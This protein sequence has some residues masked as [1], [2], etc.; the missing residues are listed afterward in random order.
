MRIVAATAAFIVTWCCA[1]PAFAVRITPADHRILASIAS[2]ALSPDGRSVA[3]IVRRTDYGTDTSPADLTIIDVAT[4]RERRPYF[5]RPGLA[6]PAW[7]PDG[8][9]LAFLAKRDDK[10]PAQINV[11]S[12]GGGDALTLT[13]TESG[14]QQFA[15]R[16][17]GAAIAYVTADADAHKAAI[18]AHHDYFEIV[19]DDYRTTA[20]IPPSHIWLVPSAGGTAERLTHGAWSV[21]T[22]YPP[23]PPSSPLSWSRD[24]TALL[25][26][27]VPNTHDGDAYLS[28]V[29]RL[30][31]ATGII[32]PLTSHG[33]LEGYA[34]F[35]P[36]GSRIAY[37]YPRDGDP[38]S[39]NEIFVTA[40]AGDAGTDVSRA[41]DRNVYRAIWLPDGSILTGAHEGTHSSLFRIARDGS[42]TKIDTGDV[43]PLV[44]YWFDASVSRTGALAFVGSQPHHPSELFYA[45]SVGAKPRRLTDINAEIAT[46][47]Q[48]RS[49]PIAW[50]GT[51]G[52]PE[53]GVVTYPPDFRPGR[54]YPLVVFVH[55]GPTAAS[56]AGFSLIP[57]EFAARGYLV[58]EPNY[59]GS[60]N[61]GNVY[62]RSIYNDAGAGPG[63][64]VMAGLAVLESQGHVDPSRIAVAGWSY[65][66]FMTTWLMGH[67]HVWKTAIAGA[68]VTN[69]VDMYNLGDGGA[70]IAFG[71]KGSPYVGDT[72]RD[73]IAQSPITEAGKTTCPVLI[74]HDVDDV[75]VP[76][77]QSY[78]L[79]HELSDNHVP[80]TF[81]GIPIAGHN[82]SDPVRIIE[83]ETRFL[84]WLDTHLK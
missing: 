22:S 60:D 49:E 30:E 53:D 77:T 80:V 1:A 83:R 39:E 17:D 8:S 41:L 35:S 5:E 21:T 62:Q 15:W 20:E 33:R 38:E 68:A 24:G 18:A 7:S 27:Q 78:E 26:T 57:Q 48:G 37:L 12:L 65:G 25:F 71:F 63:R 75:R 47:E 43:T 28:R 42:T 45:P 70:S 31:T 13:D 23:G 10:S 52:Q 66:G 82:P 32:T 81:I 67:Y 40:Q 19:D 34:T 14:V 3:V 4:G 51:E 29:M 69:W 11:V 73:Y 58:F 64:D 16:P 61:L 74:M 79:Y 55:G 50:T 2:P 6:A 54:R 76:I 56:L 46:R 36:D 59:R 84:D 72:M 44:S 9:H